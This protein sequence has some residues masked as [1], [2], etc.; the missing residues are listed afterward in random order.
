MQTEIMKSTR[1]PGMRLLLALCVSIALAGCAVGPD[2]RRPDAPHA[3]EYASTPQPETT[4]SASVHGGEAQHLVKSMDIP[5]QWWTLFRSPSLNA[6]IDDALAHNADVEAAKAA[7]QVAWEN[8]YAQRGAYFPSVGAGINPTRQD[9]AT[10]LASPAASNASLYSLT[11]AQVSVSYAPDI[12]GGTR[13]QVESSVAQANAQRFELE[14]TYLTLTSNLVNAA[15][16]EASL[17]AQIDATGRI[18]DAQTGILDTLRRQQALGDAAEAAVAAQVTVLEQSRAT[19]PPL[20]K[21]LSQQRDLLAALTGRMPDDTIDARFVL[22]DL[23]LPVDLPLSLPARLVEQRP[24]VRAADEQWHAASAAIGVAIADR[25]PNVQIDA[26]LGSA[27]EKAS[28]LFTAGTGFWSLG[29]NLTQP[30]YDGGALKHKQRAAEA[31]YRQAAA[32]YRGTVIAA[33]QNVADVLHAIRSDAEALVAA[34]R[35]ERAAAR[36]LDI[37]RRQLDLGDISQSV[38]LSAELAWQQTNIALVQAR[39]ARFTDTAALFQA[40]GGGWWNRHDA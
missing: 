40:L 30:L 39:A 33:V 10:A 4:V 14:A 25:L 32:Q 20:Q 21:Q 27:A 37:A 5:G 38:M 11:T 8:A 24:D 6:L 19:L 36:S 2:Y 12:W 28:S 17:R 13:R 35:A 15:I 3:Q 26:T 7:L 16:E 9:I 31:G 29:A 23:K 18:V 1:A 34:E 22:D